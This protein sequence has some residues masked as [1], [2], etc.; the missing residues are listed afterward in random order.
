MKQRE[1]GGS[2]RRGGEGGEHGQGVCGEER[3]SEGVVAGWDEGESAGGGRE[4]TRLGREWVRTLSWREGGKMGA[5]GGGGG[6]G[7]GLREAQREREGGSQPGT[8]LGSRK[9]GGRGQRQR[10]RVAHWQGERTD[11]EEREQGW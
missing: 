8:G 5:D 10:D 11:Y 6:D 9:E 4:E 3:G 2:W 7:Q 1:G